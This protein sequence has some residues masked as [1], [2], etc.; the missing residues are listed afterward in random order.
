M[1]KGSKKKFLFLSHK[2]KVKSTE[3]YQD[4]TQDIRANNLKSSENLAIIYIESEE[5]EK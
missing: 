3:P 5:R 4:Y 1:R 2:D